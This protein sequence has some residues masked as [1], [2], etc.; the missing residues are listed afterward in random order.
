MGPPR[1]SRTQDSGDAGKIILLL[2]SLL[3][4]CGCAELPV[5]RIE[6][7]VPVESMASRGEGPVQSALQRMGQGSF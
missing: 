5:Y 7:P 6:R 2:A 4:A 1:L 3:T